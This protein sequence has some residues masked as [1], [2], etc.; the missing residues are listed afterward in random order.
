[1]PTSCTTY[2]RLTDNAQTAAAKAFD[3][4]ASGSREYDL[5]RKTVDD[6]CALQRAADVLTKQTETDFSPLDLTIT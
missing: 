3:L 2:T 1:M 4:M 5:I 6:Y